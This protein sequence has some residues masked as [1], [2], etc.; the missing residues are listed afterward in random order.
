MVW[1]CA[2]DNESAVPCSRTPP[3]SPGGRWLTSSMSLW[4]SA[5]VSLSVT[6][7]LFRTRV[8]E[9]AVTLIFVLTVQPHLNWEIDCRAVLKLVDALL[10]T[11]RRAVR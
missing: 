2:S 11:L 10:E 8:P 7:P 5:R 9:Y 1:M 4:G 3:H 6:P